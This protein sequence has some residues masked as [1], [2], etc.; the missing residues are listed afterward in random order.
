MCACG[1][2][3][4][5]FVISFWGLWRGV[6]PLG[7]VVWSVVSVINRGCGLKA[8]AAGGRCSQQ[9]ASSA[10]A[11]ASVARRHTLLDR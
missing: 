11:N 9:P 8:P 2:V 7:V 4:V 6:L 3:G 1:R 10:T 5:A